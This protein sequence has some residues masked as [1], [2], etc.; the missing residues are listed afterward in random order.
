MAK[1]KKSIAAFIKE[2]E[3]Y[4][5][6]IKESVARVSNEREQWVRELDA[7]V[8]T[9]AGTPVVAN[10]VAL[11]SQEAWWGALERT[12]VR[13]LH[14]IWKYAENTVESLARG[15]RLAK[16]NI[17]ACTRLSQDLGL[18][19]QEAD[20]TSGNAEEVRN[21]ASSKADAANDARDTSNDAWLDAHVKKWERQGVASRAPMDY[22]YSAPQPWWAKQWLLSVINPEMATNMQDARKFEKRTGTNLYSVAQGYHQRLADR[23]QTQEAYRAAKRDA[24]CVEQVRNALQQ[25]KSNNDSDLQRN[26]KAVFPEKGPVSLEAQSRH[27]RTS[28]VENAARYCIMNN[29][30]NV[31]GLALVL[32][33]AQAYATQAGKYAAMQQVT[34]SL[35]NATTH[36]RQGET[37][38]DA[39]LVELKRLARKH[40]SRT[41]I[42]LD[43]DKTRDMTENIERAS[44]GTLTRF[45]S[46]RP[47]LNNASPFSSNS[48]SAS[49]NTIENTTINNSNDNLFWTIAWMHLLMSNN[50]S[51][52]SNSDNG[53]FPLLD[54]QQF[55]SN[56]NNAN[57]GL[58]FTSGASF[59]NIDNAMGLSVD[60]GQGIS[61]V[62]NDFRVDI[63]SAADVSSGSSSGSG[64]SDYSP[65]SSYDSSSS[66]N[67]GSSYDSSSS[68]SSSSYSSSSD[69]SSSSGSSCGGGD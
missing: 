52:S 11:H 63:P 64:F 42:G 51:T 57:G 29:V 6:S 2:Y 50:Q 56:F 1:T 36:W 65:P 33:D 16:D 43:T 45:Q 69:S 32:P 23:D 13:E 12:S 46:A 41:S 67:S 24:S 39:G 20:V 59:E 26:I 17:L 19:L 62:G 18:K 8:E 44:I 68:Y 27:A 35:K 9:W 25:E 21:S 30:N 34:E 48:F 61:N 49:R 38:V 60:W 5:A 55:E 10:V 7:L 37:V 66:Y 28:A 14:H 15:Q 40:N 31:A 3:A 53:V 54:P 47:L 4:L 58:G 22:D